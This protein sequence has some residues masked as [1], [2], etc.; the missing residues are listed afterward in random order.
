M[1]LNLD[2]VG[3]E[4]DTVER[5]W[6]EHDAM[7]YALAVG[8]GHDDPGAELEFTTEN[9]AGV[10]QRVLPT[11]PALHTG[12]TDWG[13]IGDFALSHAVHAE[14]RIVLHRPW[15][16]SGRLVA[17]KRL[18]GIYD[19][20]TAALVVFE[21]EQRDCATGDPLATVTYSAFIRGEGGFGGERGPATRR[22]R[23]EGSPDHEV[24]Y[25][26]P[27]WQALLYG[28]CGDRN[29][30]HSD[31]AVARRVGFDRPI[32]HGLCTLGYAGRALL[33]CVADG[34]PEACG[35][36]TA[37]FSRPVFPGAGLTV[38]IWRCEAGA[39][40]E[41]RTGDEVVIE[42]GEFELARAKPVRHDAGG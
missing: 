39:R 3:R 8:A 31:P 41:A 6:T 5:A 20:G 32:L 19:K 10:V 9:T 4:V 25:A 17:H 42:G 28:L 30:L 40:F 37:R 22:D 34:D 13:R 14:E 27:S 38:S 36:F 15:S 18:R 33:H 21:V 1:S 26:I 11:F 12:S 7:L 29:Q 35:A 23:P 2:M 24:T 16:T